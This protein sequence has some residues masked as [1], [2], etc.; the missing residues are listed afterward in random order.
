MIAR[1]TGTV[2][3]T[4]DTSVIVD[5]QGVGYEILVA[6]PTISQLT[7]G[8]DATLMIYEHI[9]EAAHDLFGFLDTSSKRLFEQLLSVSGVGPRGALAIMALGESG[10]IRKAIA[11]ENIAYIAGASGVGKKTAER[12]CVELKDKVGV[13]AGEVIAVAESD[14]ALAALETLG[15]SQG[16]A[17]QALSSIEPTKS[18][19]ERVRLALKELQS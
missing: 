3:E 14:D 12:V 8:S 16:Q 11:S 2:V 15:F 10:Q 17:K 4:T 7:T 9:R 6:E 18:T 13:I 5:V 1:I 19:E